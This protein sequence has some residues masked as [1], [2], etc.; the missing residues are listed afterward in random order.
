[1]GLEHLRL[2]ADRATPLALA[3][4]R[5]LPVLSPLA[6]LFPD[7]GLRRGSVIAVEGVGATS[8]ALAVAAGASEAG[9]WTA[10]VGASGLG[11]AAAAEVGVTLERFLAIDP[12]SRANL[13]GVLAALVGAVDL[14]LVGADVRLAPADARRLTARM[15]ERGS[16]MIRV[17]SPATG[18]D[19]GLRVVEAE[20]A[21]LGVGHGVLR[22]RRL[23]VTA[24]GRGAAARLRATTLLLP[25]PNGQAV[26]LGEP[27]L[28]EEHDPVP[29]RAL[30]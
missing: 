19:I 18:V 24:Q 15:R 14:V 8:L 6:S 12:G 20:W 27:A 26:A 3:Q 28:V 2:V 30:A 7:G 13:A 10:V 22:A 23:R 5:T 1:M 29:L 11:L 17:G 9:S 25:G 21:G 16:V 4:E